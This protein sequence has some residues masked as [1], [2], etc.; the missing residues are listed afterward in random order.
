NV[1]FLAAA[2]AN[3]ARTFWRILASHA[4]M[5]DTVRACP[6]PDDPIERLPREPA[7]DTRRVEGWM[8]RILDPAAAIAARGFPS[9]VTL[10]AQLELTDDVMPANSGWWRLE[11]SGGAGA[12][13]QATGGR[14]ESLRLGARGL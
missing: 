3:T 11:V 14:E 5:A 9:A 6:A 8:L 13:T 10:T 12:L 4:S 1:E 7:A 2:S